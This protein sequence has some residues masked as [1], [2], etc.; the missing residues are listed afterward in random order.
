MTMPPHGL[1]PCLAATVTLISG[2]K[3]PPMPSLRALVQGS[4]PVTAPLVLNPLMATGK[5]FATHV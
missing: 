3:V 5:P 1:Y 2:G 4:L